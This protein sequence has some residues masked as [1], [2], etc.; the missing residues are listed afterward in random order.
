MNTFDKK[1]CQTCESDETLFTSRPA[2]CMHD[3]HQ[4]HGAVALI[5]VLLAAVLGA[6]LIKFGHVAHLRASSA[7]LLCS[8]TVAS[9]MFVAEVIIVF[10]FDRNYIPIHSAKYRYGP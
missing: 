8:I 6:M 10:G 5:V 9:V 4:E 1:H 7:H 2:I 3:G